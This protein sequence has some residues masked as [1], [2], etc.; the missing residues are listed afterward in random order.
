MESAASDIRVH[1]KND[2]IF[3]SIKTT[4]ERVYGQY[5]SL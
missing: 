4:H 1:R 3:G 2:L 5:E